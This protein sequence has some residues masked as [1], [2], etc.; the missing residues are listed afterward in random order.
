MQYECAFEMSI[1]LQFMQFGHFPSIATNLLNKLQFRVSV[2][3]CNSVVI[4]LSRLFLVLQKDEQVP[5]TVTA[6]LSTIPA[7][8]Y[9][10]KPVA[11]FNECRKP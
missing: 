10:P 2:I 5:Q 7:A 11:T 3:C 9:E 8:T 6:Y 4:G 1:E